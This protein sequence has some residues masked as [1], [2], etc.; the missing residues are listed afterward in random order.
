MTGFKNITVKYGVATRNTTVA[1][2][3]TI[4]DV[5][6]DTT[7]KV[8]LGYGDNVQAVIYGNIQDSSTVVPDGVT[9]DVEAKANQKAV[10]A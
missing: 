9:I 5:L 8:M 2:G 1:D 4:G 10:L 3:A 7:S 6:K